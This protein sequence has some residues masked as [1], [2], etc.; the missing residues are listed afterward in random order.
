M[1]TKNMLLTVLFGLST[2]SCQAGII[3]L[4]FLTAII[5]TSYIITKLHQADSNVDKTKR[6]IRQD[7]D[8]ACTKSIEFLQQKCDSK[9]EICKTVV[10]L[11]QDAKSTPS[12]IL[13]D[14][15]LDTIDAVQK[16]VSDTYTAGKKALDEQ[17]KPKK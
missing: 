1:K 15:A 5:P 12:Q 6:L 3:K 10:R 11:L 14:A 4:T 9:N 8:T 13:E 17:V 16:T 7:K 2:L